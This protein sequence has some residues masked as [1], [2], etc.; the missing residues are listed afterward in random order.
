MGHEDLIDRQAHRIVVRVAEQQ[1]V[2]DIARVHV[3]SARDAYASYDPAVVRSEYTLTGKEELWTGRLLALADDRY[4]GFL[5]VAEV[6]DTVVGFCD[7][8]PVLV[9]TETGDVVMQAEITALYV[10]PASQALGVGALII[11]RV[12]AGL[13][14]VG[15]TV[16]R[17][18]AVD[19]NR[20]AQRAYASWG[21]I[22][23]GRR[24][25]GSFGEEVEFALHL[26]PSPSQIDDAVHM[27]APWRTV[28]AAG[29]SSW[30]GR[31]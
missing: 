20:A 1:D 18:M 2:R 19:G 13:R 5:L 7:C 28:E 6:D 4:R 16:V 23:T 31:V 24:E 15:I 8:Q 17:A 27:A 29:A 9:R 3:E 22:D 25:E 11:E 12:D 10:T 21:F 26:T 30:T 14:A